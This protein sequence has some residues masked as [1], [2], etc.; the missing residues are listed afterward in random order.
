M[1]RATM[2]F[3]VPSESNVS[4]RVYDA[5][6]RLV[7]DLHQGSMGAGQYT[8]TWDLSDNAGGRVSRGVY[9]VRLAIGSEVMSRTVIVGR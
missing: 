8:S 2:R 9:F 1:A 6:G 7:R 4:L 3:G 5:A